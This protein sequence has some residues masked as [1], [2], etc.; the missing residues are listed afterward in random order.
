MKLVMRAQLRYECRSGNE[1]REVAQSVNAVE[2]LAEDKHRKRE[3][4]S[5]DD[6]GRREERL[7]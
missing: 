1:R 5:E 3:G 6:G 7:I 2:V 4:G